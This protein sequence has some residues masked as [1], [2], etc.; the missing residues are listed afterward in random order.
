MRASGPTAENGILRLNTGD[1]LSPLRRK[2][3]SM[4]IIALSENGGEAPKRVR[5]TKQRG[6]EVS[7]RENCEALQASKTTCVCEGA[8]GGGADGCGDRQ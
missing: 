4:I 3:S 8:G 7:K 2:T 1:R 5:R 6:A